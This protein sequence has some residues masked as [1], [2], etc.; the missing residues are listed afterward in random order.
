MSD[1]P[2]RQRDDQ[3]PVPSV[4]RATRLRPLLPANLARLPLL[5]G[6]QSLGGGLRTEVKL[7]SDG[8]GTVNAV[9]PLFP[10][11]LQPSLQPLAGRLF[12]LKPAQAHSQ[13]PVSR[14]TALATGLG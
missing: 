12:M 1:D 13:M 11:K 7:N 8:H 5:P 14:R 4:G 10:T 3:L 6:I 2:G 9:P